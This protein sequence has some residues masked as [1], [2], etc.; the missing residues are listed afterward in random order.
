MPHQQPLAEQPFQ[1]RTG[2]QTI[3][4]KVDAL[5]DSEIMDSFYYTIFP[6]LHPYLSYNQIVQ[7]FKPWNDRHDMCTFEITVLR[8]FKGERPA[9][10]PLTFLGPEESFLDAHELGAAG[11]LIAQDEW[12][13]DKVQRGMHTLRRTKAGL[14]MG[15]YQH[16]QVRHFHNVYERFMGLER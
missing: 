14:T 3:G 11:A 12:N 6:N 9:P 13:L 8:P 10:A 7:H 5:C 1:L 2:V 16:T 4:D 15:V